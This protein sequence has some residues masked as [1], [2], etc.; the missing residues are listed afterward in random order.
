MLPRL[1]ASPGSSIV[2]GSDL[3][4]DSNG[5]VYVADFAANAIKIYSVD[6]TLARTIRVPAPVSVEPLPGGEVAVASLS[7]KHLVDVYDEERGELYRSF[8]DD[9]PVVVQC[10]ATTLVCTAP[11]KDMQP[12][13]A[14]SHVWFYG[15][16]AGNVYVSL[17]DSPDPTIRKYDAYGY[18]AYESALPLS[19]LDARLLRRA[20][21][22]GA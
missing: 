11:V 6:G 19:R 15:D 18:V 4:V 2:S 7:S 14:T 16:S 9:E 12:A 10:D 22:V 21:P 17:T 8:G 3:Q 13:T 5:R 1:L 20:I